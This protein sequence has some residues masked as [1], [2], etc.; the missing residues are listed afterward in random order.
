MFK[1]LQNTAKFE[2]TLVPDGPILVRAQSVGLDP[3]VADM[4]FQR[5]AWKGRNTVF[6]A[7]SGLKGVLRSH[8][9]RLLRSADRF[10]CD[11][12]Q[13]KNDPT[14]CGMRKP[15]DPYPEGY[16]LPYPHKDQCAA[17]FTFGSLRLAGRFRVADAYPVQALEDET[18]HTEV[19]TGVG[20]NRQSQAAQEKVLYDTEVVVS[21]GFRALISGENYSLWQ[22]GLILNALQD[23][24]QGLVRIGG[25][26]ARGMG[27]VRLKDWR[28]ELGFV[29]GSTGKLTGALPESPARNPYSLPGDDILAALPD[30]QEA[31]QGLFRKIVYDSDGAV[32]VLANRLSEG[33]LA[34]YLKGKG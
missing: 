13:T 25:G 8:C 1:T 15:H 34:S 30:G 10:A 27:N 32:E 33:P 12:T 3:G 21:G 24:D 4:E 2:V 29:N 5:T 14:L 31:R 16:A 23:L 26:K 9:E 18:N 22:L 6:L 20:I 7:G 19:R 28:I 11:P 17:C